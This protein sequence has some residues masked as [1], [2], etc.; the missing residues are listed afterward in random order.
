[1]SDVIRRRAAESRGVRR[2]LRDVPLT[3][4]VPITAMG[5]GSGWS[6]LFRSEAAATAWLIRNGYAMDY[7]GYVA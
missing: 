5:G 6:R 3:V 1:V 2:Q 4:R 7:D